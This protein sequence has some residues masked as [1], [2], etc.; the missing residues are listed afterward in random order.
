MTDKPV[1]FNTLTEIKMEFRADF[2]HLG[3]RHP[4]SLK[5]VAVAGGGAVWLVHVATCLFW[6][7]WPPLALPRRP[8]GCFVYRQSWCPDAEIGCGLPSL[9]LPAPSRCL[10]LPEG[11]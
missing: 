2:V 7:F 6:F 10:T 1:G 3:D 11:G 4:L 8:N 9:S 5:R